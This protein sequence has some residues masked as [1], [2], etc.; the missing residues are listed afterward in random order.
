M[1]KDRMYQLAEHVLETWNTQDVGQVVSCYTSN[2]VYVDPNTRGEV[3]GST[4]FWRYLEKMFNEWE[5]KWYLKEAFL[6]DHG[7]G[8]AVMWHATIK[9]M[10]GS[11]LVEFEGMDLVLV[12][13]DLIAR[14]EVYF[15]RAVLLPLFKAGVK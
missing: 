8:C 14:N 1:D 4:A 11:E 3:K 5:M 7:V 15:D 9:R 10:E 2:L 6:F 13:N 12:D